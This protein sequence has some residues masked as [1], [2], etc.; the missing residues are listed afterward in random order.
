MGGV[1]FVG[2]E[3][4]SV[5][6][7]KAAALF[8][9]LPVPVRDVLRLCDGTR[10]VEAIA[11]STEMPVVRIAPVLERLALLGL[12]AARRPPEPRRRSLTPQGLSWVQGAEPDVAP[13]PA[14]P[15]VDF[16]DDE[17]K[18]FS[19]SFDHLVED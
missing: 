11:A 12:I 16:S 18:F 14:V 9:R 8:H 5:V 17:E 10:T 6:P 1:A 7:S 4:F 2:G 13:P 15:A 19:S 3:R